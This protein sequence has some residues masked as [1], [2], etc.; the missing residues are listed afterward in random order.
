MG[1]YF[2]LF[3]FKRLSELFEEETETYMQKDLDPFDERHPS[4]LDPDCQLGRMLK[5]LFRK[6]NFMT[7][8]RNQKKNFF[9]FVLEYIF[10]IFF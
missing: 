9:S 3:F 2:T 5:L 1:L 7:R 4:R 8:V 10:L 6:D